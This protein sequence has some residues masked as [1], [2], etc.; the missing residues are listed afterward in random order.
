MTEMASNIYMLFAMQKLKCTLH[1]TINCILKI[2]L[3]NIRR[4]CPKQGCTHQQ[5][6]HNT[7]TTNSGSVRVYNGMK[8]GGGRIGLHAL[9]S[10]L[11]E[12]LPWL[13]CASMFHSSGQ[14]SLVRLPLHFPHF[15]PACSFSVGVSSA[16]SQITCSLEFVLWGVNANMYASSW[17]KM[18]IFSFVTSFLL[19]SVSK[20]SA[21]EDVFLMAPWVTASS[22]HLSANHYFL[23]TSIWQFPALRR[24]LK[25]PV[26]LFHGES[27]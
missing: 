21:W 11:L 25:H 18:F 26:W 6:I 2:P 10:E 24:H 16:A 19:A 4:T 1:T 27:P 15:L 22:C 5:Y 13:F 7:V 8:C 17:T 3:F 12:E 9:L 20:S 14:R 23:G